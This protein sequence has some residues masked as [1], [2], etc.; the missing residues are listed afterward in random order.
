T[1]A[2]VVHYLGLSWQNSKVLTL[3]A[4]ASIVAA[5]GEVGY[6]AFQAARQQASHFNMSTPFHAAIYSLMAAGAVV[7]VVASAVVGWSAAIDGQSSLAMPTRIAIAIGLIG[8]T[9][10]T[11]ITAFRL[12]GNMSHHIGLERVGAMRMPLT[13]WSLQVGDLRPSHFFATH[14][15]QAVPVFGVVA[16]R[17]LPATPAI[18]AVILFSIFWTGLTLGLFQIAL[19]G[20]PLTVLLGR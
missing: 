8:G 10:L 3:V 14:M 2:A 7:L 13:G 19:S 20:R 15:I 1:L 5:L 17:L 11:L 6:I 4:I 16:T 9:I 18:I 12:G